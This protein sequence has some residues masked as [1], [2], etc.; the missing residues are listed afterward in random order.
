MQQSDISLN[1]RLGV[2]NL[3][4]TTQTKPKV[5][6]TIPSVHEI[7]KRQNNLK[8]VLEFLAAAEFV[9]AE[10]DVLSARLEFSNSVL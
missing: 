1:A 6:A 7:P 10:E 4:Q 5:I 2:N 9:A 8:D 3:A